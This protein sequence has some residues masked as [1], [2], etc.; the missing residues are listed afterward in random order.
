MRIFSILL[1]LIGVGVLAC[2]TDSNTFPTADDGTF[3]TA[4]TRYTDNPVLKL[5][6]GQEYG[7]LHPYSVLKVGDAYW[8]W[9]GDAPRPGTGPGATPD[10]VNLAFSDDGLSWRRYEDNPIF[11]PQPGT[12]YSS[13]I[14]HLTI[15]QEGGRFRAWFTGGTG[16]DQ[17]PPIGYAESADGISWSPASEPVMDVGPPGSWDSALVAPGAV[18]REGKEYR[19]YYWGGSNFDF[20]TWK[21]G[22]ATSDDGLHWE[23]HPSNPIFEGDLDSW[24]WGVLEPNIVKLGGT[25]YMLYQ[26]NGDGARIGLATSPDGISWQR[27]GEEPFFGNGVSGS[28]DSKWTEGP[29]LVQINDGWLMYYM[30]NPPE[31]PIAQIGVAF[32]PRTALPAVPPDPQP[33]D[34]V[35]R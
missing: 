35:L 16:F 18:L 8:M 19:M 5:A 6:D 2:S 33:D 21:I 10:Q 11:F 24:D 12:W 32:L 34:E 26:G 4:V 7:W 25:Y 17:N 9:Y 15:L 1:L 20:S 14:T 13:L 31:L 29:T 22:L 30:G 28:W 3:P 23:K 27:V